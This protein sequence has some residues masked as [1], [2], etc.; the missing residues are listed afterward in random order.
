MNQHAA[1]VCGCGC[2]RRSFLVGAGM[3]AGGLAA[4]PLPLLLGGPSSQANRKKE[5]AV[6]R[7]VFLYP[8][9][10]RF[11]DKPEGWWSWPGNEFDAEGR[12][13]QYTASLREMEGKLGVRV[14][15]ADRPVAGPK[16]VQRLAQAIQTE[17]PDGL[18]LVM[19]YNRSLPQA[20]TLLKVAEKE[21]IPAVFYIG[22]GVK[23]GS[24]AHYRRPGVYL[25]QSLDNLAAIEYGLRNQA[26]H[27]G[28]QRLRPVDRRGDHLSARRQGKR[29]D[30]P[31]RE[32]MGD[33]R[34]NDAG[35]RGSRLP[36]L[37]PDQSCRKKRRLGPV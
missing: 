14:V 21:G 18:L 27:A 6:V 17:R 15:T 1:G 26:Q 2:S 9:S 16:D 24:V 29:R 31:A 32:P 35:S 33:D 34:G 20:D 11:A 30:L 23:H 10:K 3:A 7:A 4:G 36:V 12:Q 5:P 19:F 37:P 8:P 22:L 28:V 25:V 13:K